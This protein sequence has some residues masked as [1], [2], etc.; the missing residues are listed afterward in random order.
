M[1]CL[2]AYLSKSSLLNFVESLKFSS[3]YLVVTIV[4]LCLC[5]CWQVVGI[6]FTNPTFLAFNPAYWVNRLLTSHNFFLSLFR[7]FFSNILEPTLIVFLH[8]C[9]VILD[10]ISANNSR[11]HK[12][13]FLVILDFFL[14]V[15]FT[16]ILLFFNMFHL[17]GV[18]I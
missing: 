1:G 8:P 4:N 15:L 6:S 9:E 5:N 12:S 3:F 14:L 11:E 16:P 17:L 10:I 2:F 18:V 13:L 7:E